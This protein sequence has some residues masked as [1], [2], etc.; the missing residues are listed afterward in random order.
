M[1]LLKSDVE[2]T[3]NTADGALGILIVNDIVILEAHDT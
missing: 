2:T 3:E 1:A